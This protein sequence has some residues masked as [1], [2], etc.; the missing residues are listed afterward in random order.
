MGRTRIRIRI[1][2][3]IRMMTAAILV[4]TIRRLA[5]LRRSRG[6]QL[7]NDLPRRLFSLPVGKMGTMAEIVDRHRDCVCSWSFGGWC[8]NVDQ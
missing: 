2:I 6:H 8:I 4:G 7:I 3:K 1:K 5:Q